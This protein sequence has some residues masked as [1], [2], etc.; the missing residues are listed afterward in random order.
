MISIGN[1]FYGNS[2]L[3]ELFPKKNEVKFI[4]INAKSSFI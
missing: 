1:F 2:L 3:L 4:D